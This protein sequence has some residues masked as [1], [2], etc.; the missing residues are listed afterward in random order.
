MC[1]RILK[2]GL[3]K[4]AQCD[5]SS[6]YKWDAGVV[7]GEGNVTMEAE[8]GVIQFE[9]GGKVHKLRWLLVA[10][11]GKEADSL[12]GPP[13]GTSPADTLTLTY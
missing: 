9:D 13:K 2:Q 5:P 7:R 12:L 4:W 6:P 11:K 3:F 10:E 8:T 1:L